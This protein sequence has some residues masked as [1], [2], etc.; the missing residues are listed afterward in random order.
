MTFPFDS[1]VGQSGNYINP[2]GDRCQRTQRNWNA[3]QIRV[4]DPTLST[5]MES[6]IGG[7][8]SYIFASIGKEG[9]RD[10]ILNPF[11]FANTLRSANTR[12]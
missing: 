2:L 12:S 6:S 5:P 7:G 10:L 4:R 9:K 1:R 8:L 3:G 11:A